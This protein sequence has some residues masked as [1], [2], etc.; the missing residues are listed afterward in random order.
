MHVNQDIVEAKSREHGVSKSTLFIAIALTA[1]IGFIGG[2]R[3]DE[4]IGA[5][6]PVLGLK[7]ATGKVDLSSV[8][9]TYQQL[10]LHFDG[11][12]D[13][14]KLI[15]GASRGL[16]AAAGDQY[17]VYMNAQEASDFDK[18]LTGDIGA[19]VGAEIG[20]KDGHPYVIRVLADN[21]AEKAGV[22]A[23]DVIITVNDEATSGWT[24]DKTATKIRGDAGTTVKL[25]VQ[26]GAESK[27]FTLTRAKV[28]NPSVS[29]TIDNNI[30]IMTITRFDEQTGD[31]ARRAAQSFKQAGVKGVILDLRGN[32]GGYVT[33]AQDVAG[34]WLNDKVVVSERTNGKVTDE[35]RSGSNA[36]LEGL[37]TAVVVNGGSASA[38]EIVSG[39]LQDNKAATLV[40][41]KTF[42]KGTVQQ[43]IDFANGTRLKV[44]VGRWYTPNGKNITKEGIMPNTSVSLTQADSD[45]GRD[46]QLDAAKAVVTK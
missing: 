29:S 21:P 27:E 26:R 10:K 42:G 38:S 1:V 16:V 4:I 5:V 9:A 32:G 23:G 17:T 14:K 45:A 20:V 19:G 40:G 13:D 31:E 2:T 35:L 30:G 18:E 24:S 37:P 15:E 12:L 7:V 6:G 41:D 36:I 25:T 28:N 22:H 39:A 46:P 34:L 33:A 11:T 43:I 8:Q 3:S 44:T